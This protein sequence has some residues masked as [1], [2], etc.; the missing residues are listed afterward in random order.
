M[1]NHAIGKDSYGHQNEARTWQSKLGEDKY[2]PKSKDEAINSI[3]RRVSRSTSQRL[4]KPNIIIYIAIVYYKTM[5]LR[6]ILYCFRRLHLY[7]IGIKYK[8][9]EKSYIPPYKDQTWQIENIIQYI[10]Y[11]FLIK[12]ITLC[13]VIKINGFGILC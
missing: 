10:L 7:Y 9:F 13:Q 11:F 12:L 1:F 2:C 5:Y 3:S 4:H 6:K 8:L